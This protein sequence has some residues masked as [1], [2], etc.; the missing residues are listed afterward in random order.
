MAREKN[1]CLLK[2]FKTTLKLLQFW[3]GYI[4][5]YRVGYFNGYTNFY[6]K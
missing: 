5:D 3:W 6:M 1:L 2:M 4:T